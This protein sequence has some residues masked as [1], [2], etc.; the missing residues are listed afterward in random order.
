MT[1]WDILKKTRA[2]WPS[3]RNRDAEGKNDLLRGMA[4]S[5][6]A[7]TPAIL[8]ENCRDMEEAR[9][10]ISDVMLDRL[11]LDEKRLAGMAE[12][13]RALTALP[14]HTGRILSQITRPNGMT[15]C[16]QQ[17]PMGL[18]AIIYES[19]PN[20]TSD[21]A[22]LAL[23]SGNVCVLRGGKEAF[24][25]ARAIVTALK[26]GLV[27]L[28]LPDTFV[29][30]VEDTTRQSATELMHAVGYVDLLIPR[31][32][33]GLIRACVENATVPC[34][35]TGTGICHVYVDA[36]A[37]VDM[38]VN[39]IENAKASRPSVCNAE[40]VCLVHRAIAPVFLPKLQKRLTEEREQ[41]GKPPV[42]LR[43]DRDSALLIPGRPA[44][45]QDFDT[46]FLDYILAVRL[47]DSVEQAVEHIALHSTG[48]SEA[49]V[50]ENASAADQ[51]IAGVDSAAVYVNASTRFTDGGE[52]GLGCEMG[53]STQKLHARGPMGLEELCSYKY[54]IHGNGQIR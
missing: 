24:R 27:E 28:G 35:Q 3:I 45:E 42:E 50:T 49:I 16:K 23:K 26:S 10:T 53:I 21:A 48:H 20:V 25:S 52:F 12:G 6:M 1:T 33:P 54:V 11:Y 38:A 39:I 13:I 19:R 2:A 51:F 7:C 15:I 8:A 40:E 37:D 9:G 32:G 47:V 31:G 30:L 22:A 44:G 41:A 14:D 46:E 18:I 36:A 43:L 29:N 34:I 4:D 5:L 17:V